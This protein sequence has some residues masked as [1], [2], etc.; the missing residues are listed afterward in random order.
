MAP[1]SDQSSS[2]ASSSVS[3]VSLAYRPELDGLRGIAV[4]LVMLTH[5]GLM[6]VAGGGRTGLHIFFVLSGY[7]ITTIL[8]REFRATGAV[9]LRHF[10][11]RRIRRLVPGLFTMVGLVLLVATLTGHGSEVAPAALATTLYV[12]NMVGGCEVLGVY[13]HTWSLA[14]E[15][16]FYLAWP[17]MLI[18]ASRGRWQAAAMFLVALAVGYFLPSFWA[19]Q[20]GCVTAFLVEAMGRIRWGWASLLAAGVLGYWTF[21]LPGNEGLVTVTLAAA[22]IVVDSSSWTRRVLSVKPLV[23]LGKV[24]YGVYLWHLPV[25]HA[26]A[27]VIRDPVATFVL[28]I[29]LSILAGALST[30]L[31]EARFRQ[32]MPSR[33]TSKSSDPAN[34]PTNQ[35]APSSGPLSLT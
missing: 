32:A 35:I 24:S 6:P 5:I 1:L 9:D 23:H 2:A 18:V 27:A 34:A 11:A 25:I 28:A 22:V 4:F 15:E 12:T 21:N 19:L 20:V 16:Q 7:L 31:V 26:T 17:L 3:R 10:Y 13:C 14:T 8:L 33:P 29:P 30:Y